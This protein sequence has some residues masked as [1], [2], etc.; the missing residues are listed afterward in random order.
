[1]S[2]ELVIWMNVFNKSQS[3]WRDWPPWVNHFELD[4]NSQQK[5]APTK[6][7]IVEREK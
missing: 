3:N 6:E 5:A 7:E 2:T 1:M 4:K